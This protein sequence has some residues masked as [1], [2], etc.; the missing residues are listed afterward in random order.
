[1]L[2][3]VGGEFAIIAMCGAGSVV[4]VECVV[5]LLDG[6]LDEV[7]DAFGDELEAGFAIVNP[8]LERGSDAVGKQSSDGQGVTWPFVADGVT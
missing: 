1:M 2:S 8:V 5:G 7:C 3:M 4:V 6:S